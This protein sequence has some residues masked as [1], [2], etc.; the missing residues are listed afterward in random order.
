MDEIK[1]E[2]LDATNCLEKSELIAVVKKGRAEKA[3]AAA[4]AGL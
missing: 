1:K 3:V 2:K 4:A